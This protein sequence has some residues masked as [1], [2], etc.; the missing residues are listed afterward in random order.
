M[1][2]KRFV[3]LFYHKEGQDLALVLG[4]LKMDIKLLNSIY[5]QRERR[6]ISIVF[7]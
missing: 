6:F 4:G 2:A 1:F 5:E 3:T 7:A